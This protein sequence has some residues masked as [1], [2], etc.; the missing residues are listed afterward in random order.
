MLGVTDKPPRRVV[1]SQAFAATS[2]LNVIKSRIVQKLGIRVD[3][4]ELAHPDGRVLIFEVPS[5]PVGH[6]LDFDGMYLMRA[7]EDLVAMTPDQL[8]RIFDDGQPDWFMQAARSLSDL[9]DNES[10][11]W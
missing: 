11:L 2:D 6:P 4:T 9:N 3:A 10:H 8:F 5:R 7:G 1:G